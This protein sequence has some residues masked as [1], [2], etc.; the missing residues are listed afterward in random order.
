MRPEFS[1]SYSFSFLIG[2]SPDFPDRA[3]HTS[4]YHRFDLSASTL[5]GLNHGAVL[6]R[7]KLPFFCLEVRD[8]NVPQSVPIEK[9]LFAVK[10][11]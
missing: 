10:S 9:L 1:S 3:Q 4:Q 2:V 8:L 7:S 11:W 6:A 5:Q